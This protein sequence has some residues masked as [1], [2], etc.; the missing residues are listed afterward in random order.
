MVL[1]GIFK[2]IFWDESFSTCAILP[3]PCVLGCSLSVIFFQDLRGTWCSSGSFSPTRSVRREPWTPPCPSGEFRVPSSLAPFVPCPN[4]LIPNLNR[5]CNSVFLVVVTLQP[6]Q[7]TSSDEV[8][9]LC[10]PWTDKAHCFLNF[11][12]D[13]SVSQMQ[14]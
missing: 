2:K 12:E 6:C 14:M 4:L 11:Y 9:V 10:L 13:I 7:R 5:P 1:I 8:L 3:A